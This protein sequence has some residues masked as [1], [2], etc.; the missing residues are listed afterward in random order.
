MPPEEADDIV[1][2]ISDDGTAKVVEA[3]APVEGA[4]AEPTVTATVTSDDPNEGVAE[5]RRQIENRD[6][7]AIASELTAAIEKYCA[8]PTTA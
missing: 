4:A 5:L 1:F 6:A 7:L 8:T 2:D 3:G